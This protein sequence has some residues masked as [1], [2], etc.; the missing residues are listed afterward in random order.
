MGQVLNIVKGEY[1]EIQPFDLTANDPGFSD[2]GCTTFSLLIAAKA[3][4]NTIVKTITLERTA[5]GQYDWHMANGD[6]NLDAG[7][8]VMSI[9]GTG[10]GR[11]FKT[12]TT[13]PLYLIVEEDLG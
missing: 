6:A 5:N 10:P 8:Y 4:P 3:T 9:V 2:A 1:G 12:S 13:N 7:T 11:A